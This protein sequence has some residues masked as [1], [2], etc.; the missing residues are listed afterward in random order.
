MTSDAMLDFRNM[1]LSPI[2]LS[3][4]L[5]DFTGLLAYVRMRVTMEY[6]GRLASFASDREDMPV[7]MYE[8]LNLNLI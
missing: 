2:Q 8:Y 7:N 4:P 5:W 6:Q 3:V 1:G